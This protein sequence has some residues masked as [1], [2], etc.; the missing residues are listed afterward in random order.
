LGRRRAK[1]RNEF[2]VTKKCELTKKMSKLNALVSS[3]ERNV[4]IPQSLR[5]DC[6]RR[7]EWAIKVTEPTALSATLLYRLSALLFSRSFF[8][9]RP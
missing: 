2:L 1:G 6:R 7:Q 3:V 5:D 4:I 8:T 9:K